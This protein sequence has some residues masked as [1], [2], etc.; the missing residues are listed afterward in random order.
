MK[1]ALVSDAHLEFGQLD[2]ENTEGADVLI[3]AGD[4]CVA[5]DL[6]VDVS[7]YGH[8]GGTR[9]QRFHDFFQAVTGKFKD[10]IYVAGNHEHYHG[11]FAK[12][13]S[14]LKENLA[15][16]KNLHILDKETVTIDDVTF[17]GGTL[18]TDFN[19][20]DPVTMFSI[21]SMMNDFIQVK[22]SNRDQIR[23]DAD[24]NNVTWTPRFTPDDAFEDHCKILKV[25]LNTV[26]SNPEGK[27]VVVGHHSPSRQSTHPRYAADELMNGGYS[28][29]LDFIIED[30]PQIKYWVHGHTHHNFKYKIGET[31]ILCNPRGYIGY[32]EQADEFELKYFEV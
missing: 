15:Y 6:L 31:T 5:K 10:V 32:E 28:S 24:G 23:V 30:R 18:W 22:N 2:L 9:S 4:I 29:R 19:N 3:L 25:I 13:Y 17:I 14:I 8:G 21:S 7:C 12:T 11:D 16:L 20:E 26:D 1:I 27:F